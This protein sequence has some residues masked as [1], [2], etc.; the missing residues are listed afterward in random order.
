MNSPVG[1]KDIMPFPESLKALIDAPLINKSLNLKSMDTL[2]LDFET[3]G[4]EVEQDKVL[5][6][7]WVEIHHCHIRLTSA[8]HIVLNQPGL[9]KHDSA[10]IHHLR[11]ETLRSEGISEQHAFSQLFEAMKGKVVVAH[12]C[13]M[14]KRFFEY[15][16]SQN[17]A[18]ASLPIVWL[19]TLKIEQYRE[20]LRQ[21]RRDW[22]LSSVRAGHGLPDYQAHNAL[23]DAIATAE[24]YLAQVHCLFGHENAP[25][26]VVADIS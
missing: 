19:D 3:S 16:L 21:V 23:N 14:E 24:L 7:G 5:S 20:Q 15:H 6:M 13:V 11:P 9:H 10:T 18:Q 17:Y 2:V 26:H 8:R 25:L 12:G 4:F 1:S 22:R